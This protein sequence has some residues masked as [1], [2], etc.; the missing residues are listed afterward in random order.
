MMITVVVVVGESPRTQL[1]FDFDSYSEHQKFMAGI[2][3]VPGIALIS[4]GSRSPVPASKALVQ[5]MDEM[6]RQRQEITHG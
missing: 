1:S 5:I 2:R 4:N 6:A 3:D